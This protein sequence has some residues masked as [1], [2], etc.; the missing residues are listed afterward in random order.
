[1]AYRKKEIKFLIAINEYLENEIKKPQTVILM[2]KLN[3]ICVIPI[4]KNPSKYC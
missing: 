4:Q 2:D 1:M 3:K